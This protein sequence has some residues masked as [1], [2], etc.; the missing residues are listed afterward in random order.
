MRRMVPI[1]IIHAVDAS[2]RDPHL[3]ERILAKEADKISTLCVTLL[4]LKWGLG[5]NMFDAVGKKSKAMQRGKSEMREAGASFTSVLQ[6]G[7]RFTSGKAKVPS[8]L[9]R[10]LRQVQLE[11]RGVAGR[12]RQALATDVQ[13]AL[14]ELGWQGTEVRLSPGTDTSENKVVCK[15][16]LILNV[17]KI[18]ESLDCTFEYVLEK[19]I[20]DDPGNG[21]RV[22]R[23]LERKKGECWLDT[24]KDEK[25]K[26]EIDRVINDIILKTC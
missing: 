21:K 15:T 22:L 10:T 19:M 1:N 17:R 11:G 2:K 13:S 16:N 5:Q 18:E 12:S 24:E 25:R 14:S 8:L 20:K 3:V 6:E 7:V 26:K 23:L 4:G 9:L